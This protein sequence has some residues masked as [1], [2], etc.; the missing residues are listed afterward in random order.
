MAMLRIENHANT[1]F[2]WVQDRPPR[3]T[4]R[5]YETLRAAIRAAAVAQDKRVTGEHIITDITDGDG[6]H[7]H[8][9]SNG[10][11]WEGWAREQFNEHNAYTPRPD[12]R[13]SV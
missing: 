11:V 4:T 5:T 10:R 8:V 3:I 12:L 9:S 13:V 1:D 7:Y 2:P 6:A